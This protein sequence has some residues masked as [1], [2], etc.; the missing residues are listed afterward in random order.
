MVT[1]AVEN[2]KDAQPRK[3]MDFVNSQKQ[4]QSFREW[5]KLKFTSNKMKGETFRFMCQMDVYYSTM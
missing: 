5:N 1:E 3:L 4:E 2:K